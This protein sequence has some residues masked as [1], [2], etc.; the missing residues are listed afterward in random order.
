MTVAG[1]AVYQ[2]LLNNGTPMG[3]AAKEVE[4]LRDALE[5]EQSQLIKRYHE[6]DDELSLLRGGN[7]NE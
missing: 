5:Y 2:Y 6:I 1:E 7:A 3:V 4:Y